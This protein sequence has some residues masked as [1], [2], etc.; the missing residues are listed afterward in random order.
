MRNFTYQAAHNTFMVNSMKPFWALL[1]L[2]TAVSVACATPIIPGI[3]PTPIPT[4]PPA[5]DML[6]YN[7]IA[8]TY[9]ASLSPG[10]E[11]AGAQM[12]YNG[13]TADG[14]YDVTINGINTVK[15]TGDSFNWSGI[16]APGTHGK[17]NLRITTDVLGELPV[18][19]SATITV[20]NPQPFPLVALPNDP[21]ALRFN[22]ILLT[23]DVPVG[24]NIPG[25]TLV[26]NGVAQQG[27]VDVANIGGA[28][29][30][31]YFSIGD[32][33]VW[34]GKLRE[35][36]FVKYDL[37]VITFDANKV[38]VGGTADLLVQQTP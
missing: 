35:N 18:A 38:I 1:F 3:S 16:I 23:Y 9:T 5:G 31:P 12:T 29:T 6:I 8:P 32:S 2:F 22:N 27:G 10:E 15:R 11:I 33:L 17:F 13:K 28:S 25:T 37:R 36:V 19:G 14:G 24:E 26:Y 4:S 7:K 21:N 34:V 30:Y 20:L